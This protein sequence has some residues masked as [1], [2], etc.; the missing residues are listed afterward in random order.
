MGVLNIG[1]VR[2]AFQGEHNSANT[3]LA[4][5]AVTSGG[6]SYVAVQDVPALV[7]ISNTTY[8]QLMAAKGID[9]ATGDAGPMPAHEWS[10][11]SVRFQNPNLTWGAYIDVEG[12]QGPQG[13]QGIQGIQG[14]TGATGPAGAAGSDGA[15]FATGASVA[16]Y[17]GS[18]D[19]TGNLFYETGGVAYLI[20]GPGTYSVIGNWTGPAGAQG[21]QGPQGDAGAAGATGATGP[22]GPT[23][24]QGATG[25][26]GD[27]MSVELGAAAAKTTPVDADKLGILDSAASWAMKV[28][29]WGN[30][31]SAIAS[32][33]MTMT[34][35]TLTSPTMT[36]PA[37]NLGSDATGDLYYRKADGAFARLGIG[38]TDD[39]LTVASGLPS[40]AAPAGGGGMYSLIS[41]TT[42]SGSPTSVD[43]TLD[44]ST[45]SAFQIHLLDVS[46][47]SSWI[48]CYVV[49]S[50]DNGTSWY[51]GSTD[52]YY[53]IWGSA[54]TTTGDK[55]NFGAASGAAYGVMD[56]I[57]AG[58]SGPTLLY[59][60]STGAYYDGTADGNRGRLAVE[61]AMN[62]VRVTS[63]ATSLTA[64]TI[65]LWG[66]V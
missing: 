49:F 21:P 24:P 58:G 2:I 39:V 7:A 35:K 19:Y 36:S 13:I 15:T 3:Y 9:G 40:W 56:I 28:F 25:P 34:N 53:G 4:L 37:I 57:G 66:K 29:T 52:Y 38:S 10:G 33:S 47:S 60:M 22:T 18:G 32:A 50:A 26:A 54:A 51:T 1:R 6:N 48:G 62:K 23:G 46:T 11:T 20:T 64:G 27:N 41:S 14:P 5:D 61:G 8:W 12:I 45:Y 31:K 43:L 17:A 16:A 59:S 44:T 42:I 30:L 65:E 55:F 63:V